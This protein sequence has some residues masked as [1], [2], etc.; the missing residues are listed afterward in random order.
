MSLDYSIVDN[1]TG[2]DT[3]VDAQA[4]AN[5]LAQAGWTN[6]QLTPDQQAISFQGAD[7]QVYDA[8]V[9]TLIEKNY[10]NIKQ[11]TPKQVD[12]SFVQP[13]WRLGIESLPNDDAVKKAYLKSKLSSEYGFKDLEDKHLVGQGSDW[14]FY[15]KQ[16]GKWYSVT[17]KKGMDMSDLTGMI[18]GAAGAVGSILGGIGGTFVGGATGLGVGALPG[19]MVGSGAGGLLGR[20]AEKGILSAFDPEYG[21]ALKNSSKGQ[22]LGEEA[23]STGI[24]AAVP[25]LSKIPGV[26]TLFN[27]GIVSP[28]ATAV[29]KGA[30]FF[31]RGV[32]MAGKGVAENELPRQLI[33]AAVPG[34][35]NLQAAGMAAQVGNL[36]VWAAERIP[37][38]VGMARK[39]TGS[40]ELGQG[41][42]EFGERVLIPRNMSIAAPEKAAENIARIGRGEA[43][44]SMTERWTMG[45]PAHQTGSFYGNLA[46]EGMRSAGK[47]ETEI[48][49]SGIGPKA[50]KFGEIMGDIADAGKAVEKGVDKGMIGAARGVQYAGTGIKNAGRGLNIAGTAFAPFEARLGAEVGGQSLAEEGLDWLKKPKRQKSTP[51]SR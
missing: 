17:N 49:K 11:T 23:I 5:H 33:T 41:L 42:K 2:E 21:Q 28:I 25:A 27:K 20:T 40:E 6:V 22:L 30:Q 9:P 18:P 50:E 10:G 31:G 8:D 24:D 35:G 16:T 29:G 44:M 37:Q 4:I 36:P 45:A 48:A 34:L 14:N 15:N 32:E 1:A 51:F 19:A 12:E 39:V 13:S 3:N 7:G 46:E 43:P 38:A 26:S 47:T